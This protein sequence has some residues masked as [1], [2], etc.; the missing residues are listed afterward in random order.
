MAQPK[1]R[2]D[3]DSYLWYDGVKASFIGSGTNGQVWQVHKRIKGAMYTKVVKV[4]DPVL[5]RKEYELVRWFAKDPSLH[6]NIIQLYGCIDNPPY[7]CFEY[8][9]IET[10]LHCATSEIWSSGSDLSDPTI[11]SIVL[12][13]LHGLQY[14]HDKGFVHGDLKQNNV[15]VS[16]DFRIV[17]LTDFGA[18]REVKPCERV[19]ISGVYTAY[20]YAAPE[21]F[22]REM[23]YTSD[24][25]SFAVI[26]YNL[27]SKTE[28]GIQFPF[29]PVDWKTYSQIR[30]HIARRRAREDMKESKECRNKDQKALDKIFK[31]KMFWFYLE[32]LEMPL[33][34]DPLRPKNPN[35]L[36]N[37]EKAAFE[38][39]KK[40]LKP[41]YKE[42]LTASDAIQC[43]LY[44]L[45]LETI[46]N[47]VNLSKATEGN[48]IMIPN[49]LLG[50]KAYIRHLADSTKVRSKLIW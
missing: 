31:E 20:P 30:Q 28:D 18:T 8:E 39:L 13:I 32:E 29:Y 7:F 23:T 10:D 45:H 4:V 50:P 44:L 1:I 49:L 6:E 2:F 37:K 43:G 33:W 38:F 3:R 42:R 34:K 25:F 36:L 17:K 24:I 41:N 11:A 12:K 47:T 35:S 26:C 22:K 15:L 48:A 14:M 46:I 40:C 21:V 16:R 9:F 27:W 5:G 19:L